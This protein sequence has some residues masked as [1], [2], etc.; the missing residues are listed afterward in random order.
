MKMP[1][2]ARKPILAAA[3]AVLALAVGACDLDGLHFDDPAP[4]LVVESIDRLPYR[5]GTLYFG[6]VR[7][8]G[9]ITAENIFINI[10]PRDG[11]GNALGT[12]RSVVSVGYEEETVTTGTTTTTVG[13]AT[14]ILEPG[15]SGEFN[16]VVPI[17]A[18]S[19]ASQDVSFD[20]TLPV[21]VA[22]PAK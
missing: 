3:L 10:T 22:E 18:G 15:E 13:T 9:G 1:R 20:F 17:A 8:K 6:V 12:Y 2:H 19:I 21:E 11:G 5:G 7:N 14:N 4:E 16:V